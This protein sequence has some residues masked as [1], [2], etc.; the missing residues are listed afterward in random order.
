MV[1][2]QEHG[3]HPRYTGIFLLFII[4]STNLAT[5]FVSIS[6][7]SCSSTNFINNLVGETNKQVTE[8][9]KAEET[10][11][12]DEK[13]LPPEFLA[14][15]G[16]QKLPFGFKPAVGSDEMIPPVG[17][18]CTKF[19]N[20]LRRYM[21]YEVN[22]S[23]PADEALAQQ[24][25]LRGCEPLPRRRCR[26][27]ADPNYVEPYPY[28]TCLWTTP[29]NSSV[30]WYAYRCKDYACLV[31]R[32][33]NQ[34]EFD[35]CKDCFDLGG[36]ESRR[37]TG[38]GRSG[39]GSLDFTIDEV[40]ATRKPGTIR[41]G[42]DIG[43]G[44]ATFAVRM[45]D[46][47][48]TILTTSMNLNGP[49]NNF[50]ASRG[51]VPLYITISQRLP[52]FDNTLDMVHSMHVLS[53]WIPTRLL[54][55]ILFDFYRVLRPGGLFWLDRFFCAGEQLEEVYEP[56]IDSVGFKRLRWVVGMKTDHPERREMYLSALLEKPLKNSW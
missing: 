16:P 41:I 43:G 39:E 8:K 32:S 30:V 47:N 18:P 45:R 52:F 20:E 11:G 50:I 53:N 6:F 42:L 29:D 21:T 40:M 46:W 35:D 4:V 12:S 44:V 55:F 17:H 14:I 13:D 56:I 49:F 48:V 54:Q 2:K 25:L 37:W 38:K 27:A 33:Q 22:G 1:S 31:H 51:V 26:P 23:C 5:F 19:P 34:R 15:A 24:L 3:T 10:D 36:R 9:Q 7:F 28:P